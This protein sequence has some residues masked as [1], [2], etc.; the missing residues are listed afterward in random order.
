MLDKD[1]EAI[2]K[3]KRAMMDLSNGNMTD[4]GDLHAYLLIRKKFNKFFS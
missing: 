1:K 2:I 3:A 4:K